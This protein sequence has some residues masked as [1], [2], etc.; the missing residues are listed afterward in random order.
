MKPS[1]KREKFLDGVLVVLEKHMKN[2]DTIKLD[3]TL[4][5]TDGTFFDLIDSIQSLLWNMHNTIRTVAVIPTQNWS[6]YALDFMIGY[7]ESDGV[8]K[9]Q[10]AVDTLFKVGREL[11]SDY[12]QWWDDGIRL[13]LIDADEKRP[14]VPS[15]FSDVLQ[16]CYDKC[17]DPDNASLL[18]QI[19]RNTDAVSHWWIR[20]M[21]W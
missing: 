20:T 6:D 3:L 2:L 12:Y 15:F 7:K 19:C 1:K 9:V 5:D 17:R 8:E 16:T 10:E 14:D 4:N 21:D 18:C 11:S 13:K